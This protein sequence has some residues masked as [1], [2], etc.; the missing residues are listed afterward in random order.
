M[1]SDFKE[2]TKPLGGADGE[3]TEAFAE[4]DTNMVNKIQA[5]ST[6]VGGA[7]TAITAAYETADKDMRNEIKEVTKDMSSDCK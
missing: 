4:A 5:I 6:S 3:I 7:E 2:G 1:R